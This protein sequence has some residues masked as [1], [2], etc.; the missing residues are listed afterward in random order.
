MSVNPL[1]DIYESH[2]WILS[3]ESNGSDSGFQDIILF[4]C[5]A[6]AEAEKSKMPLGVPA[7]GQGSD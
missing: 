3:Q 6:V 7:L 2:Q 5:F 4:L 1:S